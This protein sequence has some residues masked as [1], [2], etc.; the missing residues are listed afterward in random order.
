[1]KGKKKSGQGS[2][3]IADLDRKLLSLGG[4]RVARYP[5][6]DLTAAGLIA[7]LRLAADLLARGKL[8]TLPVKQRKGRP[9]RCHSNAAGIWGTNI[10]KYEL[11]TGYALKGDIWREHSWVVDKKWLYETTVVAEQY[12]GVVLDCEEAVKLWFRE[13]LSEHYPGPMSLMRSLGT[14]TQ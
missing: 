1:M 2:T 3:L 6:E 12:F 11:V 5:V 8:F 7:C 14:Q 10:E 9:N 13:Y 4:A